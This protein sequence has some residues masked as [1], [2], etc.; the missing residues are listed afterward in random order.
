[1]TMSKQKR[2]VMFEEFDKLEKEW[3][4]AEQDACR[5]GNHDEAARCH[6]YRK[7][8]LRV[9]QRIAEMGDD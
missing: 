4:R 2:D 9:M 6:A 1:M 3:M 5:R 7:D 8:C